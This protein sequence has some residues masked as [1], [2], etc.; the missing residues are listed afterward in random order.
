MSDP[1]VI[2]DSKFGSPLSLQIII[3]W[4]GKFQSFASLEIDREFKDFSLTSRAPECYRILVF[5]ASD[6]RPK[7]PKTC[8]KS[9]SIDTFLSVSILRHVFV[10][11]LLEKRV[12]QPVSSRQ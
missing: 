2:P 10:Q 11:I 4:R 7:P 6:L 8:A 3:I 12:K 1:I 5:T 9:G